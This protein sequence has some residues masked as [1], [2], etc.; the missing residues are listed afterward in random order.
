MDIIERIKPLVE[1]IAFKKVEIDEPLYT[2]NLIDSMGTVDLAMMLEEEFNIKID[3]RD[4]I[5]SN[6]DSIEKLANYIKSRI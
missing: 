3:T 1:E 4:I 5:E 6:F 2:S